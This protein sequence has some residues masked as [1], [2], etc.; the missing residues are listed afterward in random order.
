MGF[1]SKARITLLAACGSFVFAWN[2][3]AQPTQKSD[4]KCQL[5]YNDSDLVMKDYASQDARNAVIRLSR[6]G[7]ILSA[8]RVFSL[9]GTPTRHLRYY[10]FGTMTFVDR[11]DAGGSSSMQPNKCLTLCDVDAREVQE[12]TQWISHHLY[13]FDDAAAPAA[14]KNLQSYIRLMPGAEFTVN[15]FRDG[16]IVGSVSYKNFGGCGGKTERITATSFVSDE[17]VSLDFGS[18]TFTWNLFRNGN[19]AKIIDAKSPKVLNDAMLAYLKA[20]VTG[21][22]ANLVKNPAVTAG[23]NH[24]IQGLD[25]ISQRL[26]LFTPAGTS[27]GWGS[28]APSL[29]GATIRMLQNKQPA[30]FWPGVTSLI[31]RAKHWPAR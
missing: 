23:Y 18:K 30:V 25:F 13:A 26:S 2:A 24:E 21:M 1:T 7:K 12:L 19:Y 17:S 14:L 28:A 20:H 8:A 4:P 27:A 10:N 16:L 3:E 31:E 5:T 22:K 11:L 29:P 15:A 9:N 6:D